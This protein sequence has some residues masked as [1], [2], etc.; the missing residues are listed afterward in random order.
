MFVF[1]PVEESFFLNDTYFYR[2][3][4]PDDLIDD[5]NVTCKF[6]ETRRRKNEEE[7][8][9]KRSWKFW[10][11]ECKATPCK[12]IIALG[13]EWYFEDTRARIIRVIKPRFSVN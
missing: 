8:R 1:E 6:D 10:I 7:L 5:L 11:S 3:F 13:N 4:D 12:N 9:E 2:V